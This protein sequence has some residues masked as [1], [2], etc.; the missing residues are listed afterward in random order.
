MCRCYIYRLIRR[1]PH[2]GTWTT[3]ALY[4]N[5]LHKNL[6]PLQVA[7][8]VDWLQW[9]NQDVCHVMHIGFDAAPIPE[10][11][12]KWTREMSWW[13][14]RW[15]GRLS[16]AAEEAGEG[17]VNQTQPK[18]LIQIISSGPELWQH[19]GALWLSPAPILNGT[20]PFGVLVP[21][22]AAMHRKALSCSMMNDRSLRVS[23][24]MT[25]FLALLR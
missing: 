2:S 23:E 17:S 10:T 1:G 19:F 5:V 8:K 20:Q 14:R 25:K 18:Q 12:A 24:P 6:S 16:R 4:N 7:D 9:V 22:R 13:Q 11:S 15:N 21:R 3:K